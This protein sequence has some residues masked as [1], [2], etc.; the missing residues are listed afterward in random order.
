MMTTSSGNLVE[1]AKLIT[2]SLLQS[3]QTLHS[4]VTQ[5]DIASQILNQDGI[6]LKES[7]QEHQ[8]HLKTGLQLT[9]AGLNKLKSA[10]NKEKR[11][12]YL[13]LLFFFT[14]VLYIILRRMRV[15]SIIY[16][17]VSALIWSK[18]MISNNTQSSRKDI[19]RDISQSTTVK[20]NNNFEDMDTK[21]LLVTSSHDIDRED[22]A[23]VSEA[24]VTSEV[25]E[26]L[27]EGN[28]DDNDEG[29]K[30]DFKFEN[31]ESVDGAGEE[32]ISLDVSNDLNSDESLS[33]AL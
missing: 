16:A 15:I 8:F 3:R 31:F 30:S 13:S 17:T 29:H 32:V 18:S 7:L 26:N 5:A 25:I 2:K 10:E 1:D 23:E 33:N 19:C 12:L 9:S 28:I 24:T 20:L 11:N 4:T 6:L 21:P 14:V 27:K 22:I